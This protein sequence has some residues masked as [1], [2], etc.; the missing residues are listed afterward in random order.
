MSDHLITRVMAICCT[1]AIAL[2]A[3]SPASA[4][5]V[6]SNAAVVKSS[7]PSDALQVRWRNRSGAIAAGAVIGALVGAAAARNQYYY[8][9]GY[10][11]PGYYAPGYYPPA[12]YGYYGPYGGPYPYGGYYG[13]GYDGDGAVAAGALLGTIIGTAAA[14]GRFNYRP[15]RYYGY[16]AYDSRGYY[17]GRVDTNAVGNW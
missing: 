3:I 16:P 13:Y 10:Y 1:S 5:P 4:A 17:G 12:Y 14:Q 8:G 9:P 7:L 15:G 2:S 11:A 6:L